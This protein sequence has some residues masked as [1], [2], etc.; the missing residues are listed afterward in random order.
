VRA[1]KVGS[2][3]ATDYCVTRN[4]KKERWTAR[5]KR[6]QGNSPQ[7]AVRLTTGT[8][9]SGHRARERRNNRRM[10]RVRLI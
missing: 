4:R 5:D 3:G 10:G 8:H 1:T 7:V 2:S 6:G 9:W